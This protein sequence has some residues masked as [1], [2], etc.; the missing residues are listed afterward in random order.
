MTRGTWILLALLVAS[1]AWAFG[2]TRQGTP[3]GKETLET[4]WNVPVGEIK[5][6]DYRSG[7][8]RVT[9]SV[10][11]RKSGQG[12]FV[13]VDGAGLR[14]AP[15]PQRKRGRKQEPPAEQPAQ[16][17]F[18][19]GPQAQRFLEEIANLQAVRVL[20]PAKNFKLEDFGLAG[21]NKAQL[22]VERGSG[23]APLRLDLGSVSAGNSTRYALSS[24]DNRVYLVRNNSFRGITNVRRFMDR[25]LFPFPIQE[26]QR[27]EL[28]ERGRKVTLYRLEVPPTEAKRWG[29]TPQDKTGDPALQ[30]VVNNLLRIKALRYL[31]DGAPA[32]TAAPTL[33]VTVVKGN[34][35]PSTLTLYPERQDEVPGV[36]THTERPVALN[37][38]LVKTLL[39]RAR[40]ALKQ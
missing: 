25:E 36:S 39:E 7:E 12:N 8:T 16:D 3:T 26:A 40:A 30:E 31:P 37:T 11:P 4:V 1:L 38:G 2:A 28:Q 14:T 34:E 15:A 22:T 5:K 19:G 27:I 18:Q 23:A 33:T 17:A 20:G 13:W 32:G 35:P 10:T 24:T 9:L 29:R 21:E 6:V